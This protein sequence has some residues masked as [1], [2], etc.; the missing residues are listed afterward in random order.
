MIDKIA[1]GH[2]AIAY[3]VIQNILAAYFAFELV[4]KLPRVGDVLHFKPV[5]DRRGGKFLGGR[6]ETAL[7]IYSR[8]VLREYAL[9]AG[10]RRHFLARHVR[11][12]YGVHLV[13]IPVGLKKHARLGFGRAA[14][15]AVTAACNKPTAQTRAC[16]QR[17]DRGYFTALDLIIAR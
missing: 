6:S 17:G 12:A 13:R 1:F 14:S 11:F 4:H 2:V 3:V 16:A 9:Q 5:L 8:T 7:D 15:A 10:H